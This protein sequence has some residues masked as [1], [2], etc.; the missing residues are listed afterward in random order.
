M[1]LLTM[2]RPEQCVKSVQSQKLFK[3]CS[4]PIDQSRLCKTAALKIFKNCHEHLALTTLTEIK[5]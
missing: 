5:T 4:K 2:E 3:I 1:H